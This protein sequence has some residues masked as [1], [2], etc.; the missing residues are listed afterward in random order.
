MYDTQRLDQVFLP[1][2]TQMLCFRFRLRTL[3]IVVTVLAIAFGWFRWE[4]EQVRKEQA[5]V[6]WIVEAGGW[7]DYPQALELFSKDKWFLVAWTTTG[8]AVA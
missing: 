7:A 2:T 8:A 6:A 4:V 3:L 1:I 5:V